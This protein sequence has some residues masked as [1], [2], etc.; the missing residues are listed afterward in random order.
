MPTE[1]S[2]KPLGLYQRLRPYLRHVVAVR[3]IIIAALLCGLVYGVANGAGLPLMARY[4]FPR[5]FPTDPAMQADPVQSAL[6]GAQA[7]DDV[8]GSPDTA[9]VDPTLNNDPTD[10]SFWTL[11]LAAIWLPT[12]FLLRAVA[13]YLNTYLIQLAGVRILESLRLD[14][15]RKLQV[16]PLAFFHNKASGDLISRGLAD[17]NQLQVTLTTVANEI[18]KQPITLISSLGVL[19]YLTL[20]EEGVGLV[21]A[22]LTIV[23]ICVL[24][25]RYVGNK[26]DKRAAILQKELGSVT[27]RFSENLAV[28]REVR[29]FSLEDY[30]IGRFAAVTRALIR[31]HMKVA[32]YAL[33]LSPAIEVIAAF[34]LSV[35]F[36]YAFGSKV[37]LGAFMAIIFAL[38]ACYEPIKRLGNL[39]N[40]IRRGLA[41]LDRLDV[42]LQE[43]VSIQDPEHPTEVGRLTGSID[44]KDV[45]FSYDQDLPALTDVNVTIPDGTICALV[46]PSG[47]GKSTFANLVPRFFEVTA[48]RV[49]ID[50]IDIRQMRLADLRGN[51]GLV[52][53]DPVLF[54]D[55][56]GMN[57]RIGKPEA[58]Q[59][60]VVAA[61]K[62]A[63]AHE[64]IEKMPEGYDTV[65][66]ERGVMLS[67]GQKQRLAVGRA[68]LRDAPILILDEATSA[69]DS[70]SEEKIQ[71]ALKGLMQ[72]KTV[73]II[74]HRFSTIRDAGQILVFE[75]GKVIARGT[76][77][78]LM[79]TSELYRSLY[80]RQVS[81][82]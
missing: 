54:N 51:I 42:V 73:L 50:G 82:A 9:S 3:G 45:T 77:E 56:I 5:I 55:T 21:L 71:T 23:P 80:E 12:I 26:L 78:D 18:F 27:D 13:G 39:N 17:T 14:F 31:A 28:A 33:G 25:I 53:Q 76:H 37:P 63:F 64:F 60:E 29:A 61:A 2:E 7:T 46:G 22:S 10:V 74:A 30:E 79:E 11:F 19:T 1:A 15:F 8:A 58:T 16:L 47:A 38:Y 35:T 40:E 41:A 72:N 6:L 52:S 20:S 36:I 34:G 67:G 75:K 48:G 44:F 69:L 57:L 81:P 43:P 32:K 59:E 66:G 70:E 4:I 49:E 65:V 68:F 24:P 62:A